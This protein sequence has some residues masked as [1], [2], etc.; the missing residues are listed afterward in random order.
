MEK[1]RF[2]WRGI[3]GGPSLVV[4]PGF[5]LGLESETTVNGELLYFFEETFYVLVENGANNPFCINFGD[6][7]VYLG[8]RLSE[9][10]VGGK[11]ESTFQAELRV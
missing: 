2:G 4:R 10:E 7:S 9:K 6:L 8:L 1:T 5:D 3:F 11:L